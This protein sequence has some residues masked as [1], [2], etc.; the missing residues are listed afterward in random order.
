MLNHVVV[1]YHQ[2]FTL[3]THSQLLRHF[4]FF[5]RNLFNVT[6]CILRPEI[7]SMARSLENFLCR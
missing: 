2:Q 4:Y 5:G 7:N 6:L 3:H 1:S